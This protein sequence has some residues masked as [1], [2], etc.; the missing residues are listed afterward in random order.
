MKNL[1]F[2]QKFFSTTVFF[3][4]TFFLL[5]STVSPFGVT[6]TAQDFGLTVSTQVTPSA[7]TETR[8]TQPADTSVQKLNT[9]E[10]LVREPILFIGTT[11][12][13]PSDLNILN[14]EL[15][16]L[17]Q[18]Y[19]FAALSPRSV[20]PR[21]CPSEGWMLLRVNGDVYDRISSDEG[22]RV[23]EDMCAPVTLN[24]VSERFLNEPI[25]AQ[26]E[27]FSQHIKDIS[28]PELS[29]QN[30]P[31]SSS[32]LAIGVS[33]ALP[34]ADKTGTVTQ[35]LPYPSDFLQSSR[36]YTQSYL[37]S[38][39]NSAKGDVF[40]DIGSVRG[41][42]ELLTVLPGLS[43]VQAELINVLV[44]NSLTET[45]RKVVIASLAD[46]WNQAQLHFF[47]TNIVAPVEQVAGVL[48]SE[49]TRA[50]GF[51]TIA[52]VRNLLAGDVSAFT[53]Q[54]KLQMSQALVEIKDFAAHSYA[55][56]NSASSWYSTFN[57]IVISAVIAFA[58]CYLIRPARSGASWGAPNWIWRIIAFWS[59]FAFAWVPAALILNLLPWWKLVQVRP[60]VEYYAVGLTAIIAITLTI[61]VRFT[62]YPIPILAGL[63][64]VILGVDIMLGSLHQRNGFM[65]S[66]VLTSRRYYG[67]S[68]RT[69]LI[70]IA[71]GLLLLLPV[72]ARYY[73]RRRALFAV[74]SVGI[75]ALLIDAL[76]SWGADFGGPPG[77]V[78]AFGLVGILVAGIKFR[79]WHLLPW[80]LVSVAT[81]G[82]VGWLDSRGSANSHIG[83]FWSSLGSAE[84]V[85]LVAGKIRDVLRSF[86][87]RP[88][89]LLLLAVLI[90]ATIG[91]Y[92]GAR[93]LNRRSGKHLPAIIEATSGPGFLAVAL[94]ILTGVV[95]AVPVNDSGA[96]ML[97]EM[98]YIASP[99]LVALMS[100][101]IV[102][103]RSGQDE[104]QTLIS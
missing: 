7:Q 101:Q 35:W 69:Y 56:R 22:F 21:T 44:A 97:K 77:I 38:I 79:I 98:F 17:L 8:Q 59:T 41:R 28:W 2:R 66:L 99:A 39:L 25:T 100:D 47:A 91:L 18:G 52:D 26:V 75:L 83:R 54:P 90:M 13:G 53:A 60:T 74:F 85:A 73:R 12:V 102:K 61:L 40:I 57:F 37:S 103:A 51:I 33:A 72:I 95:I 76:P 58:L 84:S 32:S 15:E 104:V 82:L 9:S 19:S 68:N 43:R 62:K 5:V 23:T 30:S 93:W 55:A 3:I 36:E 6:A 4:I 70:L 34:L 31:F 49:T 45:P 67:I 92:F 65:G 89:I 24:R 29:E 46:Q 80:I 27:G 78:A 64:F 81:M 48:H 96:I 1:F 86:T 42:N 20:N 11:G 50:S 94:G 71:A 10:D 63:A 87:G 88:D 14:T 16:S